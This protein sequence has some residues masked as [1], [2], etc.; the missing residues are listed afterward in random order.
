MENSLDEYQLG[1]QE[2]VYASFG[3]RLVASILDGVILYIV[4]MIIITFFGMSI[5]NPGNLNDPDKLMALFG[6]MIGV[7]GITLG[8]NW[9]YYA[10]LES[11][12]KQ[13][14][15]GKMA[16]GI[17]VVSA[18]NNARISFAQAT[19]RHFGKFISAIILFIGYLMM[20]WSNKSQTLHDS[21][22]GTLVVRQ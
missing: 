10:L 22:A 11:S 16:M 7:Y 3:K 19:G 17:K 13:G 21:M 5:L 6:K 15:I 14:T 20:L 18:N 2:I 4:N 1:D 9:L 8:I 12:E